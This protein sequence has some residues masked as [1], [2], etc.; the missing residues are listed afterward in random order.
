MPTMSRDR[1][2]RMLVTSDTNLERDAPAGGPAV[3]CRRLVFWR[4]AWRTVLGRA[5]S[6]AGFTLIELLIAASLSTLV[7]GLVFNV[8]ETAQRAQLRD[9]EW[10]LVIQEGRVGLTRMAREIRQA[11]SIRSATENS[12]DFYAT[13]GGKNLEIYYNCNVS[14]TGTSYYECVR[15]QAEVGQSLPA[16][17]TATPIVKDVLNGTSADEKDAVFKEYSPD[18]I[19]PDLVTV[20]LVLP[21]SGT[22]KLAA[23]KGFAHQIVLTDNAY[24]RN[25]NLGA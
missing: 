19:A 22:L 21:S 16:L 20:K 7:M 14:Q 24:I 25:M 9:S 3:P 11:Y 17:S 4:G 2:A 12:I 8:V 18:A 5:R 13:I 6:Q 1:Y 10:A 15:L 23:A